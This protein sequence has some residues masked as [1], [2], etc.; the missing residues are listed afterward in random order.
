MQRI[1]FPF[2]FP[3]NNRARETDLHE[4]I[5]YTCEECLEMYTASKNIEGDGR[6]I[7]ECWDTIHAAEGVLRKFPLRKVIVGYFA[8]LLKNLKR[9]DYWRA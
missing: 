5:N 4:Q 7:E 6:V 8:V 3:A 9:G 1:C 2:R